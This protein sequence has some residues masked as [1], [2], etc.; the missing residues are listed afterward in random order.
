MNTKDTVE[1]STLGIPQKNR[2]QQFATL[3]DVQV[4]NPYNNSF[5]MYRCIPR[6]HNLEPTHT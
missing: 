2:V 5:W 6:H 3:E 1:D 4:P